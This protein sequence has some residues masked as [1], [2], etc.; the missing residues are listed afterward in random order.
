MVL[1]LCQLSSPGYSGMT[2]GSVDKCQDAGYQGM[3]NG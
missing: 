2:I 3:G 1:S